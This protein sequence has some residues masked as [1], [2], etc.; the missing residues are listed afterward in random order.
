MG[1]ATYRQKRRFD[2]TPEPR[3]KVARS[4]GNRFV[5]Q[6][7]AASRLHYDFRLE[8]D[9][10]LKSWAV[11]KGPPYEL[12]VKRAAFEVED[13]P[14]DYMNFEGTIPQGQY[15]GGTVMVWDIGTYELLGGSHEKGD[16]KLRLHGRKLKGEWHIFRIRSDSAKPMWLLAKSKVPAKPVSAKQ[17]DSSVLTGRSMQRIASDNDAQWQSNRVAAATTTP[18]QSPPSARQLKRASPATRRAAQRATPKRRRGAR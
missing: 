18:A 13:H 10:T 4:K 16:L 9:G 17:D 14:L 15:G 6:K 12:G 8:L 11:P 3:G 1:L 2:V 7:H 5:I